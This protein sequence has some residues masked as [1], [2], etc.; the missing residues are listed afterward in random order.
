MTDAANARA[1]DDHMQEMVRAIHAAV[2][3]ALPH[4]H[5]DPGLVDHAIRDC[6]EILELVLEGNVAEW[7]GDS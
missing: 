4:L 1:L 2:N 7:L 5:D 3:R 6:Q